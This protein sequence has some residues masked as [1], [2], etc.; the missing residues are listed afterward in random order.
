MEEDIVQS[1]I[2][3][4]FAQGCERVYL[5]DNGSQDRTVE[6]AARAGAVVECI[7]STSRYDEPMKYRIMNGIVHDVSKAEGDEHVWWLWIDA[8]EFPQAPGR[9]TISQFL[10]TVDRS[11]RVAGARFVN[12]YPSPE[13]E[14]R[15]GFHPLEFQPLA[16]EVIEPMCSLGH[17]KHPL[18]RFDAGAPLLTSGHGFH[19]AHCSAPLFEPLET[20][21]VH[22]FPFREREVSQRRLDLMFAEGADGTSRAVRGDDAVAHMASR[23]NSLDAVYDGRWEEVED[24]MTVPPTRGISVRPWTDLVDEA[25]QSFLRWYEPPAHGSPL[26]FSSDDTCGVA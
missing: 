19:R 9:Q 13:V 24:F 20:L 21:I 10:Q 25:H 17:R 18:Q 5:V 3:H 11:C 15:R 16:E 14:Y 4:A 8:D 2:A 23:R 22:Q 26:G 7:F 1:T 6:I 12:H